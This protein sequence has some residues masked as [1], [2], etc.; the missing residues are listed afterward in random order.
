MTKTADG[1]ELKIGDF[2]WVKNSV[3]GWPP[4]RHQV[5]EIKSNK[6]IYKH[7]SGGGMLGAKLSFVFKLED[8]AFWENN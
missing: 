3:Q 1:F 7:L 5:G 6:I 8:R 4:T 2:V